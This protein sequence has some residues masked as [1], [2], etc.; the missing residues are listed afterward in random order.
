LKQGAQQRSTD[1]QAL[2]AEQQKT[3]RYLRAQVYVLLGF[4]LG[5]AAIQVLFRSLS[6]V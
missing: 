2:L 3:N 5:A 1:L 6:I 4:V